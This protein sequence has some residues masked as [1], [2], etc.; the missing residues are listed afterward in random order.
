M[1]TLIHIPV[2]P[3]ELID[4]VT[5]LQIKKAKIADETKLANVSRELD[6]LLA[7]VAKLPQSEE[8]TKLWESLRAANEVIWDSEELLRAPEIKNDPPAFNAQAHISHDG[9]DERFRL[10]RAINEALGSSIIEVKSH[11]K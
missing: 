5:V 2:S 9:N 8:L 11:Q 1:S 6:L 3:G 10:K 7:E 4:K